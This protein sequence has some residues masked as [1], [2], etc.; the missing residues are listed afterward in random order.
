MRVTRDVN[1]AFVL[2]DWGSCVPMVYWCHGM[3]EVQGAQFF[4]R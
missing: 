4:E 2:F 3:N 1:Q